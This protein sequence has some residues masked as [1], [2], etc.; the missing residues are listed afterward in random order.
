MLHNIR[1]EENRGIHEDFQQ[2]VWLLA[3]F[4]LNLPLNSDRAGESPRLKSHSLQ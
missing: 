4:L 1:C 3:R 2:K